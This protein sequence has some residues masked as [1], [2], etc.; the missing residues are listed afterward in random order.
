MKFRAKQFQPQRIVI[1]GVGVEHEELLETANKS[2]GQLKPTQ[3]IEVNEDAN[4]V[5]PYFVSN[6]PLASYQGGSSY[7]Q[8]SRTEYPEEFPPHYRFDASVVLAFESPNLFSGQ[9]FYAAWL[10]LSMMGSGGSFSSGGPGKGMYS[11]VY[12]NILC[13]PYVESAST[14]HLPYTDTGLFGI[15]ITGKQDYLSQLLELSVHA[16]VEMTRIE[17]EEFE[18]A[19]NQL[20]SSLFSNLESRTVVLEDLQR[21]LMFYNTYFESNHHVEM[22]D[23]LTIEFVEDFAARMLT[24]RP[25]TLIFHCEA[26]RLTFTN[27]IHEHVYNHFKTKCQ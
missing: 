7:L 8:D 17:P 11:R 26:D 3:N 13:Y 27:E 2:F 5:K 25:P 10:L 4:M 16:A 20:K 18:R 14:F 6:S 19:R 21:Q 23:G 22:I 24:R 9:D 15:W 12:Q 1:A